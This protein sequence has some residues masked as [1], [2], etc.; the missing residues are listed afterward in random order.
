MC[1]ISN[2]SAKSRTIHWVN[3]ILKK[4]VLKIPYDGVNLHELDTIIHE[5]M[6]ACFPFLMDDEIERSATDVA[7]LL[8][9]LDW[10]KSPDPE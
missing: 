9:R 7:R 4:K 5:A 8:W 1:I 10:R 3:A 2:T 6:R